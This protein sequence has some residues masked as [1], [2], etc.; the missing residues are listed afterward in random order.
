MN[1]MRVSLTQRADEI[2]GTIELCKDLPW[3][4]NS[5]H[6]NRESELDPDGTMLAAPWCGHYTP[7]A[8][9]LQ[10]IRTRI[11]EKIAIQPHWYRYEG[12]P[13]I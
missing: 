4:W 3:L 12:K 10:I 8:E 13:I 11:A 1:K 6:F 5:S 2:R 7:T 9:A